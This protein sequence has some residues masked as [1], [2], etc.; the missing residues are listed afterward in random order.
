[1]TLKR[2]KNYHNV[3]LLKGYR[4]SIRLKAYRVCLKG[5]RDPFSGYQ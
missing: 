4:I 2:R 1:M 3:K 5:G